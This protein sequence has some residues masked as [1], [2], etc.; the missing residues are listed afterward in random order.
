[1]NILGQAADSETWQ[2]NVITDGNLTCKYQELPAV[3]ERLH[4]YFL[5]RGIGGRDCLA[6]VCVNSVPGAST[7]L[8]L[9]ER[10]HNFFL[11]PPS[12]SSAAQAHGKVTS[13]PAF[14]RYRLTIETSSTGGPIDLVNP[15]QFLRIEENEGWSPESHQRAGSSGYPTLYLR[16]SG[17]TGKPKLVAH[18][19]SK[20]LGNTLNCL[21]RLKIESTDRIAV[22]VPIF[23]MYGLGAA[24]LPSIAVGASIDLQQN[25]NLLHF[26]QRERAF[27]PNVTFLTPAFCKILLKGRRSPRAYKLTVAAGDRF[28]ADAF[29]QYEERFGRIVNLYGSTEMGALAA[30]EPSMPRETRAET[31]GQPMPGV[32]LREAPSDTAA[33]LWCQHEYGFAGYVDDAGHSL[34]DDTQDRW[35]PTKDLGRLRT[36][37]CLE[38]L[39]RCDLSVNRDGLLVLFA[40]VERAIESIDGIDAVAVVAKGESQRGRGLV[41]YCVRAKRATTTAE[42]L[43]AACF[44][45]LPMRSVPDRF[46]LLQSLPMLPSGKVDRQQLISRND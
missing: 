44:D 45:R 46:E 13:I 15:E 4:Q 40:D 8:Y 19:Q 20:L 38:V 10:N 22:P 32:S 18:Q 14:C 11:L 41:A 36:D 26:L 25:A 21:R 24:L 43:R 16:T 37:G 9:L 31:V 27:E 30:A 28:E 3:F 23:H 39:G 2:Q 1:M 34:G 7:L 5:E 35:F 33:Q 42:E 6:F 12:S 29:I 17:S